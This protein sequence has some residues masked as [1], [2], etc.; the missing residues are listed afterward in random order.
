MPLHL[1]RRAT[2]I[3][4]LV[5]SACVIF[6]WGG[7]CQHSSRAAAITQTTTQ[8][9]PVSTLGGAAQLGSRETQRFGPPGGSP[10]ATT[11]DP[12][13]FLA[14]PFLGNQLALR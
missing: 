2:F 1:L 12:A 7:K 6:V 8:T 10:G 5:R 3:T 11:E 14:N 4:R 9:T 13:L